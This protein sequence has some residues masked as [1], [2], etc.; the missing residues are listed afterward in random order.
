MLKIVLTSFFFI[1]LAELV[2]HT[3]SLLGQLVFYTY[4]LFGT[5]KFHYECGRIVEA[6]ESGSDFRG[7]KAPNRRSFF[8]LP[9]ILF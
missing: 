2:L 5:L 7:F 3:L 9:D 6:L 4:T 8:S 1:I